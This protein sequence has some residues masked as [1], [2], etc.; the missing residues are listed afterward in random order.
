MQWKLCS[1]IGRE[2]FLNPNEQI[3][4][5]IYLHK[6]FAI[7]YNIQFWELSLLYNEKKLTNYVCNI[8]EY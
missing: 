2:I 5:H 4:E 3:F 8:I 1:F 7:G 6:K